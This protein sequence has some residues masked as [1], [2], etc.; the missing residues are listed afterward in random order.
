MVTETRKA[1]VR[2]LLKLE[3]QE[4]AEGDLWEQNLLGKERGL[5]QFLLY[6]ILR[7][8]GRLDQL[9]NLNSK[10]PMEKQRPVIRAILRL[11][12]FELKFS[13]AP[14]HACIDQAVRLTKL[15]GQ[16]YAAGFVNALLRKTD[17]AEL[18]TDVQL[19]IPPFIRSR[20]EETVSAEVYQSWIAHMSVPAP[21]TVATKDGE[22]PP[23]SSRLLEEW[24]FERPLYVSLEEGSPSTW[25]GYE[26]GE[27]WVMSPSSA[28]VV[29]QL[30]MQIPKSD[31]A[32]LRVLD[33]CAAPGSK[34][35]RLFQYGFSVEAYDRS[36]KRLKKFS[37]NCRRMKF[38]IPGRV[39]DWQRS[40]SIH[41]MYDVILLDAPCSA[42]GIMRRHPEIRWRRTM[43]DIAV[44]SIIQKQLI[45]SLF[46]LLKNDGLFVYSVC[47]FFEEEA[48]VFPDGSHCIGTW[49]TPLESGEDAFY[50]SLHRRG[51][52]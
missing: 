43:Q 34:S 38:N 28:M 8:M 17:K 10:K 46:P 33:A 31:R 24:S 30:A 6:G 49:K 12:A 42:L 32:Q 13:R 4:T 3:Q 1:V 19:N 25:A 22:P 39:V 37:E 5:G 11:G 45:D 35:L 23:F 51:E 27:W 41:K 7:E 48:G 44:N 18:S 26:E 47:S 2:A 40:H 36:A 29:E 20:V 9:L 16:K 50:I 14:I 21:I 15:N 52:G